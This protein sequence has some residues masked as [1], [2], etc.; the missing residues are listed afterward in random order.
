MDL[1]CYHLPKPFALL[2]MEQCHTCATRMDAHVP[3]LPL[4]PQRE[5]AR[6]AV[7]RA[8]CAVLTAA[9]LGFTVATPLLMLSCSICQSLF[10]RRLDDRS[11]V[12]CAHRAA[13]HQL[14]PGEICLGRDSRRDQG[15]QGWPNAW[16]S[17]GAA[18]SSHACDDCMVLP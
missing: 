17:E 8:R 10:V 2:L 6:G 12:A 7:L 4:P 11:P 5:S 9:A 15:A 16:S 1:F 13:S 3:V 18:H 14:L